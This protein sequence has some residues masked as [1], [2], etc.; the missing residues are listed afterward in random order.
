MIV[1]HPR[2]TNNPDAF[3]K[4]SFFP[5]P[6]NK[7]HSFSC[8][9]FSHGF[10]PL[11]DIFIDLFIIS[12]Q[13]FSSIFS[14]AGDSSFSYPVDCLFLPRQSQSQLSLTAANNKIVC[15]SP[16]SGEL[17]DGSFHYN[18]NHS[19]PSFHLIGRLDILL[20]LISLQFPL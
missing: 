1:P 19:R 5:F 17:I 12:T 20:D 6:Q 10:I 7:I 11:P 13:N 3:Q 18:P 9:L 4:S 2:V 14:I 16:L 8:F 15:S